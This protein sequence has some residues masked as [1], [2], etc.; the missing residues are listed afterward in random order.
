MVVL[1]I[2]RL[3]K[4]CLENILINQY[5]LSGMY[6]KPGKFDINI[7]RALTFFFCETLNAFTLI[8]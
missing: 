4:L 5:N 1:I 7:K 3:I 6:V 2:I 8:S